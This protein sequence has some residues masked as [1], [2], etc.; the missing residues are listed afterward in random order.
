MKW[1][2]ANSSKIFFKS[3]NL[4][5]CLDRTKDSYPIQSNSTF[6]HEIRFAHSQIANLSGEVLQSVPRIHGSPK[7]SYQ[8]VILS[9]HAKKSSSPGQRR[10]RLRTKPRTNGFAIR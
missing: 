2:F 1:R 9:Y 10:L 3:T 4:N 5:N 7:Q 6:S 8:F